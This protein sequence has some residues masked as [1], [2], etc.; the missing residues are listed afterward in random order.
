MKKTSDDENTD[1]IRDEVIRRMANTPP[2]K[3][4]KPVPATRGPRKAKKIV[5]SQSA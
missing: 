3:D 4:P 2:K 5:P 1:A